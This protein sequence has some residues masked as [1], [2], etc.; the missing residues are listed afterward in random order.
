M[1][2]VLS[3]KNII[4]VLTRLK[5]LLSVLEEAEKVK[6][7]LLRSGED[8]HKMYLMGV[9]RMLYVAQKVDRTIT[10]YKVR[11]VARRC[12]RSQSIDPEPAAHE[13]G[14]VSVKNDWTRMATDVTLYRQE[15]HLSQSIA[16]WRQLS[17]ECVEEISGVL[18]DLS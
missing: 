3:W 10:Q 13:A 8:L 7:R 11:Q 12:N 15:L 18:N 14:K 5:A 16:D 6:N 9:D 1:C 4:D 17:G 2:F